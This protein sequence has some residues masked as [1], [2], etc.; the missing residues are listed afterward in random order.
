MIINNY[1]FSK[2]FIE[3]IMFLILCLV[4]CTFALPVQPEN[5]TE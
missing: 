4:P 5:I 2:Y 3:E 1:G